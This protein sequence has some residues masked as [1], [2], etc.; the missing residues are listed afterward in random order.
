MSD[1]CKWIM[2]CYK[3]K[4]LNTNN[5][6]NTLTFPV[7]VSLGTTGFEHQT[8]KNL[9]WQQFNTEISLGSF[10]FNIKCEKTL[11]RGTLNGDST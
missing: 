5:G 2:I 3:N 9:K 1:N 8:E 10:I 6:Q 7:Q 4:D 11:N